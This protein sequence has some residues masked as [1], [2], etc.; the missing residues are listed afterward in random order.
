M[1]DDFV[2]VQLSKW[3][4]EVAAGGVVRVHEGNRPEFVF[5]S[6]DVQ[7]VTRAHD[8]ERVLK[9]QVVGGRAL[10]EIVPAESREKPVNKTQKAREKDGI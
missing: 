10:F 6:G 8:W 9:L 7:Y 4:E 2:N 1:G 5:K 3:G